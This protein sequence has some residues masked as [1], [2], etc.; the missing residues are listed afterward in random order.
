MWNQKDLSKKRK[1]DRWKKSGLGIETVTKQIE[2]F[3]LHQLK[4]WQGT[5]SRVD[6]S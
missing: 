6:L 1:Y 3:G 4:A 5:S 2:I